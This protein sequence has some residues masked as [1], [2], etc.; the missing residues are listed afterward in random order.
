VLNASTPVF[1][2][3]ITNSQSISPGDVKMVTVR[4]CQ[5]GG[6]RVTSSELNSLEMPNPNPQF[7]SF[8]QVDKYTIRGE[9]CPQPWAYA[10]SYGPHFQTQVNDIDE[11]NSSFLRALCFNG[12]Y[13]LMS[14]DFKLNFY[15]ED[16]SA[17]QIVS[18]I[19]QKAFNVAS[20]YESGGN[21]AL[22]V[23]WNYASDS[24]KC[25]G[26]RVELWRQTSDTYEIVGSGYT[27]NTGGVVFHNLVQGTYMSIIWADDGNVVKV[28]NDSSPTSYTLIDDPCLNVWGPR[29]YPEFNYTTGWR[30]LGSDSTWIEN[31]MDAYSLDVWRIYFEIRST[32]DWI[33]DKVHWSRPPVSV[34]FPATFLTYDNSA[35]WAIDNN[36]SVMTSDKFVVAHEYGHCIYN[37]LCKS[38]NYSGNDIRAFQE[39][40]ADFIGYTQTNDNNE[41]HTEGNYSDPNMIDDRYWHD[42]GNLVAKILWDI[43]DGVDPK[44]YPST[45]S[46]R[47][48]DYVDSKLPYLWDLMETYHPLTIYDVW[49]HWEPKDA[50]IWMIFHHVG[51]QV[52]PNLAPSVNGSSPN[53]ENAHIV[54]GGFL[55]AIAGVLI[56]WR[57]RT[58]SPR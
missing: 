48:G 50:N 36:I 21:I 11:I 30:D 1:I 56:M 25:Q 45:D 26:A 52:E 27:N 15:I 14:G 55:M 32:H 41:L 42:H 33:L 9:L 4:P 20:E 19:A 24:A 38:T 40:F 58:R 6:N 57:H 43:Y 47:Y 35:G 5:L 28:I 23:L 29:P 10:H 49:D 8:T 12:I 53:E 31:I 22:S 16:S 39:G 46:Y 7:V 3:E 54:I 18:P 51:V 34:E 13:F 2:I 17:H 37:D 44:D